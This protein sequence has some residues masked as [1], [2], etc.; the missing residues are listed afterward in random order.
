[1]QVW[2]VDEL[3]GSEVVPFVHK[4]WGDLMENGLWDRTSVL[5]NGIEKCVFATIRKKPVGCIVFHVDDGQS[6]IAIAY[7]LAEH[8]GKGI[9]KAMHAEFE[10]QSKLAGASCILNICYPTN[11]V[12]QDTCTRL[13]YKLHTQEWRKEL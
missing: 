12:I 8:R 1:M 7:V 10:R 9:Y 2:Y 13:G 5:I 4:A 11:T 6:V 3:E